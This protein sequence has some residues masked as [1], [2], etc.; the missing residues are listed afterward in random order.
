MS[1]IPNLLGMVH[2]LPLPGAPS[3]SGSMAE[4][5]ETA[6]SDAA[7]LMEAGF[8]ALLVENYGDAPF[9]GDEVPPETLTGL[10]A[11]AIAVQER[12]GLPF[13]VNVL[14]NDALGALGVAAATGASFIRVNVLTGL[15]QTDQ[16]PLVGRAA[17]VIR[18]R[19][20]LV[21]HVEV[22]ADVMVKHASPP[23]GIDARQAA[24]DTVERGAADA[25][26]VSGSATGREPDLHEAR[27]V[28]A[29]IPGDTRLVIGSGAAVDNLPALADVAD[30]IIVGSSL[31][32][33]GD[34]AKRVDPDRAA[35]FVKIATE[36]GLS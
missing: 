34:P 3:F 32:F 4:V 16:G 6:V 27:V 33:D 8:P 17:E 5:I 25:V 20:S 18:K 19:H 13:G 23:P 2:L 21:P 26:I 7:K 29:A 31:K 24:A 9:F 28:R 12:T 1:R 14:R 35:H 36:L 15:M 11:A 30:S 22:W 10:T